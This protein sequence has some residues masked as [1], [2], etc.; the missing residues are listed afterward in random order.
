MTDDNRA[1]LVASCSECS[2]F[3]CT[4]L[5]PSA[6]RADVLPH[7]LKVFNLCT[8]KRVGVE[9]FVKISGDVERRYFKGTM[10]I[11]KGPRLAG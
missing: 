11:G 9:G 8:I 1:L 4:R 7:N 5:C 6:N 10:E 2:D 3:P